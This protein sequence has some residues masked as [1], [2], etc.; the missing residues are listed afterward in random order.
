MNI[1]YVIIIL[2]E[3]YGTFSEIIG[4]YFS[5]KKKLN[6]KIIIIGNKK[7]FNSQLRKLNYIIK[8]NEISRYIDAKRNILNFIDI[9]FEYK[10][11]F[12]NITS[13]SKNYIKKCFKKALKITNKEKEKFILINGPISKKTFLSKKYLGITEYLSKKTNSKNEV[14]LIYNKKF[15]VTPLT[16]HIPIKYVAKKIIKKKIYN[17]VLSINKFYNKVLKKKLKLAILGLNPHCETVDKFSEEEKIIIPSIKK[18][19][20]RGIFVDGPYPADTFFQKK[21]RGDQ[22][23]FVPSVAHASDAQLTAFAARLHIAETT[24]TKTKRHIAELMILMSDVARTIAEDVS[25]STR[26]RFCWSKWLFYGCLVGSGIGW[27]SLSP[28]GHD[29]LTQLAVFLLG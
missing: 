27:F 25:S 12:S 29:L 4:K 19:R 22:A 18:L 10:K 14:M 5:R 7:L 15:S 17:N 6:K 1:E 13:K 2:G 28:S 26:K 24:N 23:L 11:I 16:T 9:N 3:P 20:L 8:V 21:K